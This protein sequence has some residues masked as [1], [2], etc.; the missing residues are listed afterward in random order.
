MHAV[1]ES[2]Q[3]HCDMSK[4]AFGKIRYYELQNAKHRLVT[5]TEDLPKHSI[6]LVVRVNILKTDYQDYM[7]HTQRTN[8]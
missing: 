7:E 4:E 1:L 3:A 2:V 6:C 5:E 8:K